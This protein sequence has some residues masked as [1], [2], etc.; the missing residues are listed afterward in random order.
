MVAGL[1]LALIH[2]LE[3]RNEMKKFTLIILVFVWVML[4][5]C[6]RE[7][8]SR[9]TTV[10]EPTISLATIEATIPLITP[11]QLPKPE[12]VRL[13]DP[14]AASSEWGFMPKYRIVYYG[15]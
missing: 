15:I 1:I 6:R 3:R 7:V 11:E 4:G 9:T 5:A 2:N 10:T 13:G 14:S 8:G 12:E